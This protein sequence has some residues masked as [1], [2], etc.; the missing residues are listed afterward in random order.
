MFQLSGYMQRRLTCFKKVKYPITGGIFCLFIIIVSFVLTQSVTDWLK[1][2]KKIPLTKLVLNGELN[3]VT[4]NAVKQAVM[5]VGPLGTFLTQDV[6]QLQDEV[7]KIP[8]VAEVNI[9]KQWPDTLTVLIKEYHPVAIWNKNTLIDQNGHIFAAE[10]TQLKEQL[11]KLSGPEDSADAVLTFYQHAEN[12]LNNL[13]LSIANLTLTHRAAWQF[14]LQ[15]GIKVKLGKKHSDERLNRFILLYKKLA[16]QAKKISYIDLRYDTGAAIG[17]LDNNV[18]K[19][20]IN[21]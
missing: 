14:V 21:D 13:H 5:S 3:Y 10:L 7:I 1:D 17:W 18:M 8:W 6:R 15:N 4:P 12:Q 19:E 9:K 2:E 20:K 16:N 11:V